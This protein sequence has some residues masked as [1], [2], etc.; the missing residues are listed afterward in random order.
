MVVVVASAVV[1][2]GAVAGTRVVDVVVD[3][4][5]VVTSSP[6]R[7]ASSICSSWPSAETPHAATSTRAAQA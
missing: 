1:S 6:N 4:E 3:V 5:V 7:S 2:T